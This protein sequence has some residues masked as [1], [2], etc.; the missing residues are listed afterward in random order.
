MIIKLYDRPS[1]SE[2][3]GDIDDADLLQALREKAYEF[4]RP[5]GITDPLREGIA[6]FLRSFTAPNNIQADRLQAMVGQPDEAFRDDPIARQMTQAQR[7]AFFANEAQAQR[8]Y[9]HWINDFADYVQPSPH[10]EP[11]TWYGR[12]GYEALKFLPG[13]LGTAAEYAALGPLGTFVLNTAQGSNKAREDVYSSLIEQG[14]SPEEARKQATSIRDNLADFGVRGGT[15]LMTLAALRRSVQGGNPIAMFLDNVI[16]ASAISG[17]GAIAEQALTDY[18]TG[19]DNPDA[20][21]KA[22]Q[23][24]AMSTGATGLALGLLNWGKLK[25]AQTR[26]NYRRGA[27]PEF[28]DITPPDE[29]NDLTPGNNPQ[30]P[31]NP[32]QSP[33]GGSQAFTQETLQLPEYGTSPASRS[34]QYNS[35]ML[36]YGLT[37]LSNQFQPN[38]SA[39][40]IAGLIY[41]GLMSKE[42]AMS[43]LQEAGLNPHQAK[44]YIDTGLLDGGFYDTPNTHKPRGEILDDG[45]VKPY[46]EFD[47]QLPRKYNPR[48]YPNRSGFAS[49]TSQNEAYSGNDYYSD[50]GGD[51]S[52]PLQDIPEPHIPDVRPDILSSLTPLGA[53]NFTPDITPPNTSHDGLS[54]G[55]PVAVRQNMP[56]LKPAQAHNVNFTPQVTTDTLPLD[57]DVLLPPKREQPSTTPSLTPL[58]NLGTPDDDGFL[59]QLDILAPDGNTQLD[60]FADTLQD[61]RNFLDI[62]DY[63]GES[64]AIYTPDND[65][66]Q[67]NPEF[68]TKGWSRYIEDELRKK[69]PDLLNKAGFSNG[70]NNFTAPS[71]PGS[72]GLMSIPVDTRDDESEKPST[73]ALT[74][75]GNVQSSPQKPIGMG[76]IDSDIQAISDRKT[77]LKSGNIHSDQADTADNLN[78]PVQETPQPGSSTHDDEK[79]SIPKNVRLKNTSLHVPGVGTLKLR[80]FN[81]YDVGRYNNDGRSFDVSI[82]GTR[83]GDLWQFFPDSGELKPFRKGIP[84]EIEDKVKQ[85]LLQNM[86]NFYGR[87]IPEGAKLKKGSVDIS[88]FDPTFTDGFHDIDT[89]YIIKPHPKAEVLVIHPIGKNG[90][91]GKPRYFYDVRHDMVGDWEGTSAF[92][93]IVAEAL[94]QKIR[95]NITDFYSMGKNL[96]NHGKPATPVQPI[97]SGNINNIP[98]PAASPEKP[99][100]NLPHVSRENAFPDNI[101]LKGGSFSIPELGTFNVKAYGSSFH[102]TGGNPD[103]LG[104]EHKEMNLIYDTKRREF[105][106]LPYY[107]DD[108]LETVKQAFLDNSKNFY[109]LGATPVQPETA[110][111]DKPEK[112]KLSPISNYSSD[113]AKAV[114]ERNLQMLLD[115][116][117]DKE[118]I[119]LLGTLNKGQLLTLKQAMKHHGLGDIGGVGT[120]ITDLKR[121]FLRFINNRSFPHDLPHRIIRAESYEGIKRVLDT[122]PYLQ[123]R[124]FAQALGYDVTGKN[125]DSLVSHLAAGISTSIGNLKKGLGLDK[126]DPIVRAFREIHPAQD[127]EATTDEQ[128]YNYDDIS[129]YDGKISIPENANHVDMAKISFPGLGECK[130]WPEDNTSHL[131]RRIVVEVPDGKTEIYVFPDKDIVSKDGHSFV[132]VDPRTRKNVVLTLKEHI[133]E[134]YDLPQETQT[135]NAQNRT[136]PTPQAEFI[137]MQWYKANNGEPFLFLGKSHD[138]QY[139]FVDKWGNTI[140]RKVFN[141]TIGGKIISQKITSANDVPHW[142]LDSITEYPKHTVSSENSFV[143]DEALAKKTED[144]YRNSW[145]TKQFLAHNSDA[146]SVAEKAASGKSSGNDKQTT[147]IQPDNPKEETKN[148]PP[149]QRGTTQ[150]NQEN[151]A[152][153]TS[154][155]IAPHIKIANRVKALILEVLQDENADIDPLTN[156]EL[157]QWA[158]EAFGG[159]KGEGKFDPKDAYDALELGINMAIKD[160]GFNLGEVTT[161]E[162]AVDDI[163]SLL[164]ILDVIPTQT[165]RTDTQVKFQQFST[166]HSLAYLVNWLA[167]ISPESIVLEPS[168]GTGDLAVFANETARV[169]LLNELDPKRAELLDSLKLNALTPGLEHLDD[170]WDAPTYGKAT[171]KD[172]LNLYDILA[173]TLHDDELPDRV[174]MNPPFSAAGK[175][176]TKNDNSNGFEHV[177]Q[178]L[179]LLKDGGRLVAIL[180]AGRDGKATSVHNWLY[181]NEKK[182]GI[183]KKYNIRAVITSGGKAYKKFGTTFGNII[184]VIDKNG[185]TPSNDTLT[186]SFPG[187][188]DNDE[189]IYKLFNALA[190]V[191]NDVPDKENFEDVEP[192][193]KSG[194]SHD[195]IIDDDDDDDTINW[196]SDEDENETT[197]TE[198][199]TGTDKPKSAETT[200]ENTEPEDIIKDTETDAEDKPQPVQEETKDETTEQISDEPDSETLDDAQEQQDNE[201]SPELEDANIFADYSPQEHNEVK[202]FSIAKP[203]PTKLVET[204]NMQSVNLPPL[205]YSPHLPESMISSGAISSAQLEAVCYAGQ[206]FEKTIPSGETQGFILGDGTGTGKGRTISAIITDQLKQGHGNGKAVWF[207]LS[208]DLFKDAKRDIKNIGEDES[209]LFLLGDF[210]RSVQI[211]KEK[212]GILFSS[213][214]TLI[215]ESPKGKSE[216]LNDELSEETEESN[217]KKKDKKNFDD[218]RLLQIIDWLGKDFDGFIAFDECHKV[219]NL[220]DS[221]PSK[222][223]IAAMKL[224]EALPHARILYVSATSATEPTGLKMFKR[225]GFWGKD[226]NT[227]FNSDDDFASNIKNGGPNAMEM[228]ARDAKVLGLFIARSISNEGI[229]YRRLVH[230]LTPMQR[231]MYNDIAEAWRLVDDALDKGFKLVGIDP[232]KG[233]AKINQDFRAEQLRCFNFVLMSM[234]TQALIDDA[235]KQY[236]AGNSI[237]IQIDA[238]Y[239]AFVGRILDKRK[240]G[241]NLR[242]VIF[243]PV[244]DLIKFVYDVF[245]V[246]KKRKVK[247]T[248]P[249]GSITIEEQDE[250]D[251]GKP[252]ISVEARKLRDQLIAR[253]NRIKFNS[254]PLDDIINAFGGPDFVAE[255]TGRKHRLLKQHEGE[256]ETITD[257]GKTYNA[258]TEGESFNNSA[259]FP[260]TEKG[261]EKRTLQ[262]RVLIFSR[263][264]GTGRSFHA[265]KSFLNH[266]KR[267]HYL[268]DGG[269][270]AYN[271]IQGFGRTHRANQLYPPE[272]VLVTTDIPGEIRFISSIVRKLGQ[273]GAITAGDRKRNTQGLYSE[274]DNLDSPLAREAMDV[275]ISTLLRKGMDGLPPDIIKQMGFTP[276]KIEDN[277]PAIRKVFNRLLALDLDTQKTF[278]DLFNMEHEF[279][280][281]MAI[282]EGTT[283]VGTETVRAKKLSVLSD[284]VIR[285]DKDTGAST[286]YLEL[287]VTQRRRLRP[288]Y[289]VTHTHACDEF[290]TDQFGKVYAA[291]KNGEYDK[292]GNLIRGSYQIMPDGRPVLRYTLFT[293]DFLTS[294]A[295]TR[296]DLDNV[297]PKKSKRYTP[298][299][300]EKAQSLWDKQSVEERTRTIYLVTGVLLPVWKN[301]K[302]LTYDKVLRVVGKNGQHFLGRET[303]AINGERIISRFG[304]IYNG[305]KYSSDDILQALKIKGK[306]A[307]LSNNWVLKISSVNGEKRIEILNTSFFDLDKLRGLGAIF[308]IIGH[309][310]RYFLPVGNNDILD[311]IIKNYPVLSLDFVQSSADEILDEASDIINSNI[312]DNAKL[313][314]IHPSFRSFGATPAE[315]SDN[316]YVHKSN[317]PMSNEL[318]EKRYQAAK[319]T[320]S[321]KSL[322]QCLKDFGHQVWKGR[323]D[324]PELA[325]DSNLLEA[326]EWIRS[327]KRERQ[328]NVHETEQRLRA[329]LLDLTPDDFD[330]FQRAMELR[331]L[332]ETRNADPKASMPWELNPDIFTMRDPVREEYPRIMEHVR[333]NF[334]VQEAMQKADI[335]SDDLRDK[336]IQAAEM[337]GMFDIRDRLKRKHYFRH[338]V[339]EYYNMQREGK[340]HPTFKNPDR[341]GYLKHREGS[342]KDI[343]SNWLLAMGEVFTRMNDDIKILH[344]LLK[345]RKKYDIIEKLKQQAWQ[346]NM[347]NATE[348]L[349]KDLKD[350]PD[351]LRKARAMEELQKKLHAR[352]SRAIAKLFK[353]AA[354][355]DLPTGDNNEWSELAGRLADAGQLENL[356]REEQQNLSRYIGWLSALAD[357]T[358]ARTAARSFLAGEKSRNSTLKNI[359]GDKYL[360]WK[361][362]IPDDHTLWSPSDSRLVFSASTIP[363][364]VLKL[365]MENIDELLGADVSE[366]G[367]AIYSGGNKQLWCIPEKLA[368]A[369]NSLGKKQPVGNFG[370]IMNTLMSAFKRW[371]TISPVNGR[372]VKYNW[373]NFFGDLEAVLQ[374]NPDALR[375]FKQAAKELSDTMLRGGEA[376]GLLAEFNKRGGGL[377]TEFMT[378]LEHP[379]QLRKFAHL[380][381]HDK[382]RNPV[383]FTLS[384]FRAYVDIASTLTSFRESILRYASFLSFVKLIQDNGGIP[385]YFGMSKPNEVLAL[386]DN[387]YDMAFKLANENLGAYDQLSQNMRWLRDN[388]F[389]AFASWIEVNFTRSIQ[390][391]KNIWQGNSYLEYWLRKHGQ[392]FIDKLAGNGGGGKEPPKPPKGSN[393]G[394]FADDDGDNPFRRIFRKAAKKSGLGAMRLAITLALAAPLWIALSIF[395][396]LMGSDEAGLTPDV[397]SSPFL[398]LGHNHWTGEIMYM[399]DL[400]SAFDFFRT[401]GLGSISSD[402]RDLFNGR[403]SFGQLLANMLDGPVSKFASNANPY[404]K[405]IIEALFGKRLFPSALNPS[406]IRDTG[407]F[408]AQSFGLDWYYDFLTGKPHRPFLDFSTSLVNSAK[409]EQSAYFYMLSRRKQFDEFVLEKSSDAFTQ[410]RRGEALRNAKLAADYDDKKTMI[411]FLR[412][413]AR[414]GG[415]LNSLKA[416]MRS[417]SPLYGL[418]KYRELQFV[419]WLPKEERIIL[420]RA[421][422][423]YGRLKAKFGL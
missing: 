394:D 208:P 288:F 376:K 414:E 422:R 12:T 93:D 21:L 50:N 142:R 220:D 318:S 3:A 177:E 45:T 82:E 102:I 276:E 323:H 115:A 187:N 101:T 371:V 411:K 259:A 396:W 412:Q 415:D 134:L 347:E 1:S 28:R 98:N 20:A 40:E 36:K 223:A 85:A 71:A 238:T 246:V 387:I 32:P 47:V 181:G 95:E 338:L 315:A 146:P 413:F 97:D 183:D 180:G 400:G 14:L 266:Q 113:E 176:G 312:P 6:G 49:L 256:Y 408:I 375:Y 16:T 365:A 87:I 308:E 306:A 237:V 359:L 171:R 90:K 352:Q 19:D 233:R 91:T 389:L 268:L 22:G 236:E 307:V 239:D 297:N 92:G 34:R 163:H 354:S 119:R 328:A 9:P 218:T 331:D 298:I 117:N 374:G 157:L 61:G 108:A 409:Q 130:V 149:T 369:L 109:D 166:P 249:D 41:S 29:P 148:E 419:K 193:S 329:A 11:D 420:R 161:S 382:E 15:N 224:A 350:V 225:L 339:L 75:L 155:T 229:T 344:T 38:A 296:D 285:T 147:P 174:I 151:T 199:P 330:L 76:N 405:A 118:R 272:Y 73:P 406:P 99:T 79:I 81:P 333:K 31:N 145:F 292:N 255:V 4:N 242:D 125:K 345:L 94:E 423:Y 264:G 291:K 310:E 100:Q 381:E 37:P 326:Q 62:T 24:A 304:V 60:I 388:N 363:E 289:N 390:M 361:D 212:K 112:P 215:T 210:K 167:N 321:S 169:L 393:G 283:D 194:Y 418:D 367:K 5:W 384:A 48:S 343:S 366:L 278:M 69:L 88:D 277:L 324:I 407:K 267:I 188:F 150:G 191:H 138:G 217:P 111:P 175:Q 383:K 403:T 159:T 265:D 135:Q 335:L 105:M 114:A 140:V 192:F 121:N 59:G 286:H 231:E 46:F 284:T 232:K 63:N 364:Y 156:N 26:Y 221:N 309:K 96:R 378:E 257:I 43:I 360:D 10:A 144:F 416:S 358:K 399:S 103:R 332:Y 189:E 216:T 355:G 341:R 137:P 184:V 294:Y 56:E 207:S 253:L 301:L 68:G 42:E 313:H 299:S 104:N 168:A 235:K 349:M 128:G 89:H 13:A 351:E 373:R 241:E 84:A 270:S 260:P 152:H 336:L 107:N 64:V 295:A 205:H 122:I 379:E 190:D 173:P 154:N 391:Y 182:Q 230:K 274:K 372:I 327:L 127:N 35:A 77:S 30:P 417:M 126:D 141:T 370:R 302:G 280:L 203:H 226:M 219:N 261:D 386:S 2:F 404:A 17:A 258:N 311:E 214:Q 133:N 254:T 78:L 303:D 293:P 402:L 290:F 132:E 334:R 160:F 186:Y 204:K 316:P 410:T 44:G 245:P 325:G 72:Q 106:Y 197:E 206:A 300:R 86:Q 70:N 131:G 368:D 317:Y 275:I 33:S 25:D 377:T 123:L 395:N 51:N 39:R 57:S 116:K 55:R 139:G 234:K 27:V 201:D 392:S 54:L 165:N 164:R 251:G 262:K 346:A 340:P 65:T 401:I 362:L 269:F 53:T 136:N 66:L 282:Q 320:D 281:M 337:L 250:T 211:P 243:S 319:N 23:N 124:K 248:H 227:P 162:E 271:A 18:R 67:V 421:M 398:F 273:M 380:F 7:D 179:K 263:M 143:P 228:F 247:I 385:P 58:G 357:K 196:D 120:S 178:A 397:T 342:S 209:S 356:S 80:A 198:K 353:L 240:A 158:T 279:R 172:A 185:A 322:W 195:E 348:T 252:L 153:E 200:S 8:N 314:F 52:N 222:S 202:L 287:E 170:D 244:T 129:P 213:Y 74:P 83:N 110:K 305:K